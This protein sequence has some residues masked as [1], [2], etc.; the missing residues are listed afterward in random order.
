MNCTKIQEWISLYIDEQV[1]EVTKEEVKKHL[2][3]CEKCKAEYEMML[4]AI[5]LCKELPMI[6]LPE[7]FEESLHEKLVD[8]QKSKYKKS[9]KNM[10][11][12]AFTSIAAMLVIGITSMSLFNFTKDIPKEEIASMNIDYSKQKQLDTEK[13]VENEEIPEKKSE[14]N[15]KDTKD[16]NTDVKKYLLQKNNDNPKDSVT[17]K[18]IL[19]EESTNPTQEQLSKID[20]YA[21]SE[22]TLPVKNYRMQQA[23]QHI[24]YK[25]FMTINISSHELIQIVQNIGG[26]LETSKDYNMEDIKTK[27][28]FSP[29]EEMVVYIP[30]E[31]LSEFEKKARELGEVKKYFIENEDITRNYE[32]ILQEIKNLQNQKIKLKEEMNNHNDSEQIKKIQEEIKKVN[33]NID[34]LKEE[35][36]NLNEE[37]QFCTICVSLYDE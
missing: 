4:E 17:S 27:M 5:S 2:I 32:N 33:E 1:D 6:D 11:W 22:E 10:N 34:E 25:G 36:K 31:K 12:K 3:E 9:I 8:V 28:N 18:D 15:K 13:N 23:N 37:I 29:T 26:N 24:R 30:K 19:E 7:E 21:A 35:V 20:F 14:E 16:L